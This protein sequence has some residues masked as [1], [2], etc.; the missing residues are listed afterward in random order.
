M[1]LEQEVLRA[2]LELLSS[3]EKRHCGKNIIASSKHR[4]CSIQYTYT[5]YPYY[6]YTIYVS[7]NRA[8]K[9]DSSDTHACLLFWISMPVLKYKLGQQQL[10]IAKE[11]GTRVIV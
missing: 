3:F 4:D 2:L 8:V 5:I 11:L 1:S 9:R 7:S 10:N 6:I